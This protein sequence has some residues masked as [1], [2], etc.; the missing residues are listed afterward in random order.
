MI[1]M[2]K[3]RIPEMAEI[4]GLQVLDPNFLWRHQTSLLRY[5]L[6]VHNVFTLEMEILLIV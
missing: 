6:L 2:L 5:L 4:P 3:K 1:Y